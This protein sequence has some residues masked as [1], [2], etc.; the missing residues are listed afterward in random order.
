MYKALLSIAVLIP[1]LAVAQGTPPAT[2][3]ATFNVSPGPTDS[4]A[5]FYVCVGNRDQREAYAHAV[6]SASGSVNIPALP[7]NGMLKATI[8]RAGF[9]GVERDWYPTAGQA[10]TFPISMNAGPAGYLTCPGYTAPAAHELRAVAGTQPGSQAE[11]STQVNPLPAV[12]LFDQYS[13]PLAGATVVFAAQGGGTATPVSATTGADGI[14]RVTGWTMGPNVGPNQ[15]TAHASGLP[16]NVT[17]NVVGILV[18]RYIEPTTSLTRQG[19]PGGAAQPPPA[20]VVRDRSGTPVP[21]VTV[22]FVAG[23]EGGT[24]APRTVTTGVDGIARATSWTFGSAGKNTAFASASGLPQVVFSATVLQLTADATISTGPL[25]TTTS[26]PLRADPPPPPARLGSETLTQRG[27]F[28]ST[29]AT[30][31]CAAFGQ[32]YVMVAIEGLQGAAIDKIRV[33]C[34]SAK[35]DG[36][37][38]AAST[39]W[40]SYFGEPNTVPPLPKPFS[41]SCGPNR[42]VTGIQGTIEEKMV[43]GVILRCRD[44]TS[45]GLA[46]GSTTLTATA[47]G[48]AGIPWNADNCSGGRPARALRVASD[49]YTTTIVA[50]LFSPWVI[51]GVQLICEQPVVQ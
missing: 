13:N 42:A 49:L 26:I 25:T 22:T 40:T 30:L 46:T 43:R 8:V 1:S 39:R 34:A 50:A 31:D 51:T 18:P 14:A 5:G 45:L 41:Q 21:G 17:F 35:S 36:S 9:T 37:I 28:V 10:A 44:L 47:G 12:R 19:A 4:K 15:L 38:A 27:K 23:A 29:T 6:T 11:V 3:S 24:V 48:T 20:V 7:T 32:S 16:G 2:N 33:A